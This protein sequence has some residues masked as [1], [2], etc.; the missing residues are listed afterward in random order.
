[1]MLYPLPPPPGFAFHVVE[2]M[3]SPRYHLKRDFS[4]ACGI[5]NADMTVELGYLAAPMAFT[6]ETE[7]VV[8]TVNGIKKVSSRVSQAEP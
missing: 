3:S 2:V 7:E 4:E 6:G 5:F 8:L 1:M